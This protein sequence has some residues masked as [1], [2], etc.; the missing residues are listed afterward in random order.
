LDRLERVFFGT[1]AT[2]TP[3]QRRHGRGGNRQRVRP[4]IPTPKTVSLTRLEV[5]AASAGAGD[6]TVTLALTLT[7]TGA[8]AAEYVTA[9]PLP[10]GVFVNGFRLH[11]HGVPVPGRITEKKTAL[12]VYT[13]I[14][15][16]ERRDPGLLIYT[17][18]DALEL[19]VFPVEPAT[20]SI[21]EIDFLVPAEVGAETWRDARS[22]PATILRRLG[23]AVP[24]QRAD[25]LQGTAVVGLDRRALLPVERE[26]Y[27]HLIVD[28]SQDN[29]FRGDVATALRDLRRRFPAARLGRVTLAN[30]NVASLVSPLTP[31]DE[32]PARMRTYDHAMAPTGGLL[33]DLALAHGLRQHATLELDADMSTPPPRPIFVVLGK[34]AAVRT[35]ELP[36]TTAWVDLVPGL[37]V[38]EYGDDGTFRTDVAEGAAAAPLVRA[39]KSLRPVRDAFPVRFAATLE[40]VEYWSPAERRWQT[41]ADI[42]KRAQ[43]GAWGRAV[44]LLLR[45]HDIER[46]P[47]GAG[48]DRRSLLLAGRE[49]GVM[50]HAASYI[51]VE[52]A[53]QWK[54]LEVGERRKLGQSDALDHVETPAP[55]WVWFAGGFAAW[56][57]LRR[58]RERRAVSLASVRQLG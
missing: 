39:G 21:V 50:T 26:P 15:D 12:W 29:P 32:L 33:L 42:G 10:P 5:K 1:P 36:L 22:D 8:S 17:S 44:S 28:R 57:A 14:R 35:M 56:L 52:N 58:W 34:T 54:M 45:Q 24:P 25:T 48:D 30:H 4:A 16:R 6:T 31:L 51:V 11:V 40:P 23:A 38:Y 9:L 41:V 37:E 7:N 13:T 53:A 55:G 46:N 18:P 2:A 19:R 47:G 3:Q 27:L 49:A 43:P 20:P